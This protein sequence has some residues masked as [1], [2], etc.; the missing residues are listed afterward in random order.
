MVLLEVK[1]T[2]T[3]RELRQFSVL[4]L[5]FF[6]LL[7]GLIYWRS[8]SLRAAYWVWG[9][10]LPLGLI[11]IAWPA[12]MRP[13][14]SLMMLVA[15]PIGWVVSHAMMLVIFYVVATPIG[16]IMRLFGYDPLRL[17]IDKAAQT[18]WQPRDPN[19]AAARYFQQF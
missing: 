1:A 14:F 6:V 10:A 17:K 3:R 9:I 7:G 4:W 18:Y 11:G 8:G 15:F 12:F 13:I 19:V 2:V 16:L 5:V